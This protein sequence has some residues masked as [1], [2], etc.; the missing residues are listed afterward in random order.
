MIAYGIVMPPAIPN[1]VV[2]TIGVKL[3][4]KGK[5]TFMTIMTVELANVFNGASF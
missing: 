3:M 2:M 1:K 5:K 4:T